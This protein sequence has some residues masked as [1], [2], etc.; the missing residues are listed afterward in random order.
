MWASIPD[1][2]DIIIDDGLHEFYANKVFYE[3]SIHKLRDGGIYIVEDVKTTLAKEYAEYFSVEN[4]SK[5]FGV[6]FVVMI[7]NPHNTGD[8]NL[9][10]IQK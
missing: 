7:P 2:L 1:D 4:K 6:G 10:I 9:V 8:N 3:N 5:K